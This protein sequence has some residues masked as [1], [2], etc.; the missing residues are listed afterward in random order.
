MRKSVSPLSVT[1]A[2]PPQ[3]ATDRTS[4]ASVDTCSI[5][6]LQGTDADSSKAV[7]VAEARRSQRAAG[8]TEG[9]AKVA[10]TSAT[11]ASWVLEQPLSSRTAPAS[12]GAAH[13][14]GR[15][16]PCS[17]GGL[18][19][20]VVLLVRRRLPGLESA[21]NDLH[22]DG[23]V[24]PCQGLRDAHRP[25]GHRSRTRPADRLPR[26]P[27]RD[28]AAQDRGAHPGT[29]RPAPRAV[30]PHA[31]RP[32]QPPR[33][34]GGRLVPGAVRRTAGGGLAGG[35]GGARRAGLGLRHCD[36]GATGGA[37]RPLPDGVHRQ[38]G[39]RRA[40]A[41]PRPTVGP[42]TTGWAT[43]RPSLDPHPHDRG[44]RPARRAR[45]PA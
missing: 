23:P 20:D 41:G 8:S 18:P 19:S 11:S 37:A 42:S 17:T 35:R 4:P 33:E 43:R 24:A 44:D 15:A 27:A 7:S 9:S 26:L 34:G 30:L 38:P 32:A 31:G 2:F 36:V 40:G 16:G 29:A 1:W 39:G 12:G 22:P 25:A 21:A 3:T 5:A 14:A 13:Q 6:W 28:D 10:A 45:R